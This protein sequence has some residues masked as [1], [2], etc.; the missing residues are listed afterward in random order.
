M[1]Y[2]NQRNEQLDEFLESYVE[3]LAPHFDV[4]VELSKEEAELMFAKL[5]TIDVK[6]EGLSKFEIEKAITLLRKSLELTQQIVTPAVDSSPTATER[7]PQRAEYLLFLLLSRD[8][9]DVVTGDLFE[10][11]NRIV[12][13]FGKRRADLWYYKQVV[14][15]LWPLLRRA[16]VKIGA[17][18]WLGRVLKRLIS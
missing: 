3:R 13:R 15:S 16:I 5:N 6:L 17:L 8:E 9:R 10:C 14:G 1:R 11:Y 2:S 4:Q 7:P 12:C 18:V